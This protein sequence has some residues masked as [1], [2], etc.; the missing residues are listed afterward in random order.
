ML[1]EIKRYEK[2]MNG[3][4]TISHVFVDAAYECYGLEDQVREVAGQP[5]AVWKIANETAIRSGPYDLAIAPSSRF[6]LLASE[7]AGRAVQIWTPL[8]LNV[9][10]FDGVRIHPG[11]TD[12][13]T[14]G[15]LLVGHS[16]TP[17]FDFIGQSTD[18][19]FALLA[20]LEQ[21]LGLVRIP[22]LTT[23]PGLNFLDRPFH[24]EQTPTGT[25]TIK[26]TNEFTV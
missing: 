8:L 21:D 15:C 5:V 7:R 24:Y 18:A 25:S 19:Y 10:G 26:I 6:S 2:S 9:E 16:H 1:I 22:E 14:E 20:K 11:N 23:P 12:I 3:K 17:G 4:A 13:D